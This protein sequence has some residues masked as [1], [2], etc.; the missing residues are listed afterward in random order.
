MSKILIFCDFQYYCFNSRCFLVSAPLSSPHDVC[1]KLPGERMP[2]HPPPSHSM[3]SLC[4][5]SDMYILRSLQSTK[6]TVDLHKNIQE[7]RHW[8]GKCES[9]QRVLTTAFPGAYLTI[10]ES[11][12]KST[13]TSV[14]E[15]QRTTTWALALEVRDRDAH[16]LSTAHRPHSLYQHTSFQWQR[17]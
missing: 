9:F 14:G 17:G 7:Y 4:L 16:L 1:L 2:A 6:H 12:A 13:F 3:P 5:L 10:I 8:M 11:W 15:A